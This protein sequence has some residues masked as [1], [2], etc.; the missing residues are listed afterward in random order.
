MARSCATP[1]ASVVTSRNRSVPGVL[2]YLT[3]ALTRP[4]ASGRYQ[5]GDDQERSW[6]VFG[7]LASQ[8]SA[9]AAGTEPGSLQSIAFWLHT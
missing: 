1:R 4:S 5:I 3:E 2:P 6:I 7:I 9:K 8:Q